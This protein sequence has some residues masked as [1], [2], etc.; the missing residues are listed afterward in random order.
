L[1]IISKKAA[2]AKLS[3]FFHFKAARVM[4]TGTF[5]AS[6]GACQMYKAH[7]ELIKF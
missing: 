6:G 4:K 5:D 2:A 3:A 1:S 7:R